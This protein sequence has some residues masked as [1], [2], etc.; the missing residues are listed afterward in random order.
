MA[1]AERAPRRVVIVGGGAG[2]LELAIR[3]AR[4]TRPGD[5]ARVTLVDRRPTHIWKP[6]YHEIAAGLLV[7]SEEEAGYA[8]QGRRHGFEF[9][10]GEAERLDLDRRELHLAATPYPA[11]DPVSGAR[12]GDLLP[13]RDLPYDTAVLALGSTVNDFGTPGVGEHAYRLD[14]ADESQRLHRALLAQAARVRAG[15]QD[16]VRVV[17]VGAGTTGVELAAELR[18][19]AER[20]AQYRSLLHRRQLVLT[21]VEMADR[22]LPGSPEDVSDYAQRLLREHEVDLRFGAKVVRVEADGVELDGGERL[23]ADLV[24]WASGVKARA[25]REPPAGLAPGKAGRVRVDPCLR[26]LRDDG[27]PRDDLYALG[28]CAELR[29]GPRGTPLPSTAQVAHQEARHLARSLARQTRGR[30]AL[31]FRFHYRGTL[32]SLGGAE[33]V[34]D[35]PAPG[36]PMGLRVSGLGAKIAYAGLYQAHLAELFGPLRTAA[37]TLSSAL[38]RSAQ[39]SVKLYW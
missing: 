13:A 29:A 12:P 26:V 14:S 36:S 19:A 24:V 21:V 30:A 6:R 33:A 10:L 9:V 20:L 7:P 15:V 31:P 4:L 32:V 28:D 22:A 25:L 17:I 1:E 2:G 23:A 37:L 38:R 3:L 11:E 16:A 27:R 5:R 18:A 39:P 35:L 8:A 34:G